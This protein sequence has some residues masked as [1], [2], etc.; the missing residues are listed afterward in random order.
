MG[1]V[2]TSTCSTWLVKVRGSVRQTCARLCLICAIFIFWKL[3]SANTVGTHAYSVTLSCVMKNYT[4]LLGG[5]LWWFERHLRSR[6]YNSTEL[7]RN[8]VVLKGIRS[9]PHHI[10]DQCRPL[11]TLPIGHGSLQYILRNLRVMKARLF[12][13]LFSIAYI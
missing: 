9:W 4:T 6:I 2:I 10:H 8:Y 7:H 1:T 13:Y 3:W 12:L 11:D 5:F